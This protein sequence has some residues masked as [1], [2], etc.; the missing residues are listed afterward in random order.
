MR[1]PAFDARVWSLAL[2]GAQLCI[3]ASFVFALLWYPVE[4]V[5]CLVGAAACVIVGVVLTE[6]LR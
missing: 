6:A 5:S 3:I 2:F 1:T 4:S